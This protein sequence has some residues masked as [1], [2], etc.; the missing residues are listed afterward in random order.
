[1]NTT[2]I[3]RLLTGA[4]S[5]LVLVIGLA[6]APAYAGTPWL[7]CPE[8]TTPVYSDPGGFTRVSTPDGELLF[9]ACKNRDGS[10]QE[11]QV[12][13]SKKRGK[14]EALAFGWQW[15]AR[16]GKAEFDLDY[17]GDYKPAP[18]EFATLAA[19]QD[20][21]FNRKR[22]A[23]PGK[24]YPI[25]VKFKRPKAP[26][27]CVQ[28]YIFGYKDFDYATNRGTKLETRSACF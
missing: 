25:D 12:G 17:R 11:A 7:A 23:D 27:T 19:G 10:L 28:G 1:L 15:V 21:Y 9:Q 3:L 26:F 20:H 8:G 5:A 16:E 14:P 13:Y 24:D 22:P 6:V 2:K 18:G 4:V